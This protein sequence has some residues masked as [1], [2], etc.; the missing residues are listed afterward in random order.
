MLFPEKVV[1]IYE[2]KRGER[3]S[4]RSARTSER[5][6]CEGERKGRDYY[7][8]SLTSLAMIDGSFLAP[9][10]FQRGRGKRS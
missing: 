10:L 4:L 7:S 8:E 5:R 3:V 6:T 1:G 9:P 2:E